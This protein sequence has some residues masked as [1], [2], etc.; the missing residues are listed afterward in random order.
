MSDD[1]PQATKLHNLMY[2]LLYPAVLGSMIVAVAIVA[3]DGQA[4]PDKIYYFYAFFL[5]GYFSSQHVE[6][7]ASSMRD[8]YGIG[9]F[10]LDVLEVAFLY[11]MFAYLGMFDSK[12]SISAGDE[13]TWAGFYLVLGITF[14]VPVFS[15]FAKLSKPKVVWGGLGNDKKL[16]TILSVS[17]GL[18]S[19]AA[20]LFIA[21]GIDFPF[22]ANWLVF[23]T[24]SVVLGFYLLFF[25]ALDD[26]GMRIA[27][28]LLDNKKKT[29]T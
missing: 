15:R 24:L 13:T 14:F 22:E 20:S 12:Y 5:M 19:F 7:V 10:M 21:I 23:A 2:T 28:K 26:K 3:T 8:V 4:E 27:D 11:S 16:L 29:I 9:M 1:A 17:T 6:N 18:L 25:V